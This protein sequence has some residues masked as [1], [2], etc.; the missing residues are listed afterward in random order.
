M[1]KVDVV[2]IKGKK[3]KEM[4]LPASIFDAPVNIDLMH[5]AYVRQ[6]A[7]ARLG[8]H[9]TKTRSY[10]SGGGKKPWRQKGIGRAR[11][12]R[13][14][15]PIWVGGGTVFG[16]EPRDYS[17]KL[18]RKI[19]RLAMKSI[20]SLK[21]RDEQMKIVEDFE[22]ESGKT[23]D[24]VGILSNLS[25]QRRTVV[26]TGDDAAL[27]KRAGNNIP[28]VK[29]LSFNRLRA[30]DLFYGKTVLV[31]ESAAKKLNDFYGD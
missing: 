21:V 12:G 19:K 18:P 15:S 5:Q 1:T 8:T 6:M 31:L 4:E 30:H 9:E 10:V 2:D 3:V 28:W 7:N 11:A 26:I 24:L 29:L 22:V 16:P 27:L 14:R 20:L 23:R 17:Y 25:D 13:R